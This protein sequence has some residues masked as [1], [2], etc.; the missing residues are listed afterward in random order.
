[1]HKGAIRLNTTL[2]LN[3]E[4]TSDLVD[5]NQHLND[6]AYAILFSRAVD[7]LMANIG[8]DETGREQHAYTIFTLETHLSYLQEAEE[9][10]KLEIELHLLDYDAKR[11]HVFFVMNNASGETIA[12]SEQMLMGIDT[13]SERPE[14]FPDVVRSNVA[15]IDLVD[16]WPKQAG[17]QIG[18]RRK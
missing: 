18:I 2:L 5:Y 3:C 1:M 6:A 16:K 11:L 9:G 13:K 17:S 4:V 14:V 8:L 12:T 15:T 7:Q 10:E